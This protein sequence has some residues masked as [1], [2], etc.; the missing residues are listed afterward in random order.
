V[1]INK[2]LI[3]TKLNSSCSIKEIVITTN[4]S[5]NNIIINI[6]SHLS[7]PLVDIDKKLIS[8]KLNSFSS[9][10]ATVIS[11]NI[12]ILNQTFPSSINAIKDLTYPNNNNTPSIYS[13]VENR[14]TQNYFKRE[15]STSLSPLKSITDKDDKT[16][17]LLYLTLMVLV[18]DYIL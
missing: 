6:Q 13:G 18:G 8:P 12:N 7:Y 9:V 4:P 2:E 1:D 16:K 17:I 14:L 3:F 11:F 10:R 15:L 5:V